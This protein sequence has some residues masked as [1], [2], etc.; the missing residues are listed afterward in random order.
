VTDNV[1]PLGIP[2]ACDVPP[3]KVLQGALAAGLTEVVVVGY[4]KDGNE[5]IASSEANGCNILWLLEI[6]KFRLMSLAPTCMP[7]A[8]TQEGKLLSF[9]VED[10]PTEPA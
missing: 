7:P 3:E 1:V 10:D 4:D 8:V 6:G 2:T 5:Y 9:P